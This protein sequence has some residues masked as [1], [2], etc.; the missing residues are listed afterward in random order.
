ME[1]KPMHKLLATALVTSSLP[2]TLM[3]AALRLPVAEPTR[4]D[5]AA[6]GQVAVDGTATIAVVPDT[7]TMVFE[8]TRVAP[9]R[10]AAEAEADDAVAKVLAALGDAGARPHELTTVARTAAPTH[11]RH[12]DGSTNYLDVRQWTVTR[13]VQACAHEAVVVAAWQKA[14]RGA[15]ARDVGEVAWETSR[16]QELKAEAR[17]K[18]AAAARLKAASLVEQ[19]GGRLGAPTS[20]A[21]SAGSTNDAAAYKRANTAAAETEGAVVVADSAAGTI[22]VVATVQVSFEVLR[23]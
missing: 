19:L 2:A 8:I 6:V 14:A 9:T 16:L 7:A 22:A 21:E 20:I 1:M 3:V 4:P 5:A 13:R 12:R 17:L 15:G 10:D 11:G 18:A 23:S